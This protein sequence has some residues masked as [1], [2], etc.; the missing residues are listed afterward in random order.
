MGVSG[1]HR[2]GEQGDP[3]VGY[4]KEAFDKFEKLVSQI[5]YEIVHRIYKIAVI[6]K[7]QAEKPVITN[8]AQIETIE[9]GVSEERREINESAKVINNPPKS[10]ESPIL[11]KWGSP[12]PSGQQPLASK[13]KKL[14]R[15]DPCWCGSG[16]KFKKCHGR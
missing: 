3:I 4:K 2:N 15:N 11:S 7:D 5:D 8:A 6:P 10:P 9:T 13:S 12:P 16:K 14:G 1:F